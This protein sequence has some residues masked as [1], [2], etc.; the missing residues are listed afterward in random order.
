MAQQEKVLTK[1]QI[2]EQEHHRVTEIVEG[3]HYDILAAYINAKISLYRMAT[4]ISLLEKAA[5]DEYDKF[6][7]KT[8]KYK[9]Y[10]LTKSQGGAI[11]DYERDTVFK[12]LND[13]VKARKELLKAALRQD[14]IY[15]AD[16][17]EVPRVPVK[18]YKKD[19]LN[20]NF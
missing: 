13:Q 16:G 11:Y 9:G 14:A 18:S 10:G 7:E 4:R 1:K 12:N 19:S 2:E 15:D 17:C 3:G 6:N 8:L 20:L 5:M